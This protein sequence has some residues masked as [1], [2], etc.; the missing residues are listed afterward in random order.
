MASFLDQVRSL[1]T[2]MGEA[3]VDPRPRSRIVKMGIGL[4]CGDTPKT[5]TSAL[6]WG[7][8][9]GDWSADYR[10]FSKTAWHPPEMFRPILAEATRLNPSGPVFAAMDD[11]LLRKTGRSIPGT[12]YARDPLGPPFHVN[13][14]LGQRFLQ[15]AVMVGTEEGRPWRAV[16]VAFRHVPPLK[17]PPRATEAERQA[18][19]EARKT[20]NMSTAGRDELASLRIGLD[21]LPEG[22]DRILAMSADGGFANRAFLGDMPAKTAVVVRLRKDA[23]LRKALPDEERVGPR[24]YGRDLPTPEQM[25]SDEAIPVR[26]M[27]L[28]FGGRKHT[29]KYKVVEEV[30]W[31]KVTRTRVARLVLIKPLGYRLRNGGR[32]FYRLP[33]YLF[34]IGHDID[35][36]HAIQAYLLRWEIEVSFRDEKTILGVGK[37]QVWNRLSVGRTPAFLVACYASLLLTSIAVLGDMR[38]EQFASLPKWR[39]HKPQRPSTRDLVQLLRRLVCE[40]RKQHG[41]QP[42]EAA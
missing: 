6:T 12:A 8:E 42:A 4:L 24:K 18:V 39:N 11:T 22:R 5:I 17:A 1:L 14:V 32:L 9:R 31:Q 28:F 16:P 37:A 23:K 29:L 10:L 36:E 21:R 35:I 33:G 19:K 27:A 7:D 30:C 34:V 3:V 41:C 15:T 2:Q 25:L 26:H 20:N 13:L 40:E 38:N